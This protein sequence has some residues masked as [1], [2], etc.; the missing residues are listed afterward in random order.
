MSEQLVGDKGEECSMT[1][2]KNQQTPGRQLL[3][4]FCSVVLGIKLD[5]DEGETD[6]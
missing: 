3:G 2:N 5:E 4:W 1:Q 6:E